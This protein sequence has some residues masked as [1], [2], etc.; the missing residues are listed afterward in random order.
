MLL[1]DHV[2][3]AEGKLYING[4]GWNITGP[5]PS[6]SGI[7]IYLEVPWTHTNRP[8]RFKLSLLHE[9]GQPVM[10]ST[11]VGQQ[12]LVIQ[13]E[14][15]VG[16]PPG[17]KEGTPIPLAVPINLPAFPLEPDQGFYWEAE[18]DGSTQADWHLS[19]RTRPGRVSPADPTALPPT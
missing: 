3:V 12:P 2:A 19:F 7:A 14:F 5:E 17:T 10:H 15:E 18:V 13:A 8:I 11:P 9:D 6:P 1:C 16:R 4:G